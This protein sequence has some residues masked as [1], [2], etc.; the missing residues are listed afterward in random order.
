MAPVA[1]LLESRFQLHVPDLPGHGAAPLSGPFTT[2][3]FARHLVSWLEK[4][5][6]GPLD[7]FG[8][9]MGG[10]VALEAARH[11]PAL[12]RSIA[13]LGTKFAWS[14]EAVRRELRLL[15]PAMIRAKV[16]TFADLLERR[17]RALPWEEVLGHTA[18]LMTGLGD[19]PLLT[20]EALATVPHPVRV[21]VG[22]R[23]NTVSV[24]ES[25]AAAKAIPK[26]QLEVLP[27]TP[28]PFEKAPFAR[29]ASS[30]TEFWLDATA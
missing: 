22:D 12:F 1:A 16:P 20:A 8:Y 11:Q 30:L 3:A 23:D 18:A 25:A 5:A 2:E 24:E 7:V 27:N 10:Y 17:H 15:D 6:L 28:H 9:S 14:P 4:Q 19:Q 26:G 29:I 13:T 21:T